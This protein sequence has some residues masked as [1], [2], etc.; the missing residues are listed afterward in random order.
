MKK[1]V[2]I[3]LSFCAVTLGWA[4][5]ANHYQFQQNT[6]P[7]VELANETVLTPAL[8]GTGTNWWLNDLNGDT[9]TF[10]NKARVLD[11]FRYIS[12]STNG[13]FTII[14]DSNE[15]IICDALFRTMD[16]I[17][18]NSRLS[19]VIEGTGMNSVVKVQWKNLSIQSGQPG[20]FVNFQIWLYY[21][22][23]IIEY[24]YGPSSANNASGYTT[25]SGPS[26][27]L[28]YN[29]AD[30]SQVFE[31]I[32]LHNTPANLL[33]DSARAVMFPNIQGVPPA[34]TVYRFVP[35][36]LISSVTNLAKE[37]NVMHVY[38]NPASAAL[39]IKFNQPLAKDALLTIQ[40]V[41]GK[42]VSKQKLAGARR[43][44]Q[45]NL[46]ALPAGLMLF[47]VS[48]GDGEWTERVWIDAK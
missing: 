9:M 4:Q 10:F 8:F 19:Y 47:N 3:L 37:V 23:G 7:F 41:S 31:K 5:T 45:I 48:S 22:S 38:P 17:D 21:K 24:R 42:L 16:S 11:S 32:W 12:F 6:E 30:F 26:I 34:G 43:E 20:N 2:L 36:A 39:T 15:L 27:G 1:T 14:P 13:N 29:K 46:T 18:A 25:V 40:D 35:R 28:S 33:V 44:F